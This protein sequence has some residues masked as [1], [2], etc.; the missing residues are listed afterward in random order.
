MKFRYLRKQ[1]PYNTTQGIFIF[2]N[3]FMLLGVYLYL[4][5]WKYNPEES[6]TAFL[7]GYTYYYG[8][9][10][11][12]KHIEFT[13][14]V[15][16]ILLLSL[17]NLSLKVYMLVINRRLSRELNAAIMH[18]EQGLMYT[19]QCKIP[20]VR[21]INEIII[22]AVIIILIILYLSHPSVMPIRAYMIS[23]SIWV[24]IPAMVGIVRFDRRIR[25][26]NKA[27]KEVSEVPPP[28]PLPTVEIT[29]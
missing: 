1:W 6:I 14:F 11:Y 7:G 18:R 20:K 26:Y 16:T 29:E 2:Y 27:F 28:A 19:P 17:Y 5:L 10:F 12:V 24:V 3:L 25:A 15:V 23:I 22:A 13:L 8:T 21:L 9:A 4:F